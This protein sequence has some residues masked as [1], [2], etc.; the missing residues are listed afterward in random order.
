MKLIT[1][2]SWWPPERV[3]LKE[4]LLEVRGAL[5]RIWKVGGR[6]LVSK[7]NSGRCDCWADSRQLPAGMGHSVPSSPHHS[8]GALRKS[9]VT[10]LSDSSLDYM[11]SHF[12]LPPC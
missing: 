10:Q 8:K 5:I 12:P 6:S 3:W 4:G 7:C 9:R 11:F 2:V 1:W